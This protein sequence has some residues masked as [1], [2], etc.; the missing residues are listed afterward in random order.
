MAAISPNVF[1]GPFTANGSQTAFPFAFSAVTAAEVAA[2][3][4][5][6][7]LSQALFSV[8]L[9]ENG[10]TVTFSTPP[11]AGSSVVL[12]SDPDFTQASNFENQGAYNLTTVNAVNR[13]ASIRD[14]VLRSKLA[15]SL[16]APFGWDPLEYFRSIGFRGDP[17]SVGPSNNTR[18]TL[19]LLKAASITDK[20]SLYDGSLWTWETAAAPYTADDIKVVK[21][22]ST[23]LTV[24][25]WV[26]QDSAGITFKTAGIGARA[27]FIQDELRDL[28]LNP[29]DF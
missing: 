19:A 3:V 5:G 1:S 7:Q 23:P 12:L 8:A 11:A 24:G 22:N 10:G 4:D 20:T 15:Q 21:A 28:P 16:V 17:G 14:L 18:L 25:A 6:T 27:R 2:Q 9:T 13:R 29:R 26:R